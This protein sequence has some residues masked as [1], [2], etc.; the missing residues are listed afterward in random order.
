MTFFLETYCR[1]DS[2][3]CTDLK[4]FSLRRGGIRQIGSGANMS[5]N[6]PS[7]RESLSTLTFWTCLMFYCYNLYLS[8]NNID[9]VLTFRLLL[10]VME[11]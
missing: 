10:L 9:F 5:K 1:V 8:Q 2:S 11:N 4:P 6:N 3:Q 7:H